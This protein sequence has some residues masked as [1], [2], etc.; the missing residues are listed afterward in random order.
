MA[1]QTGPEDATPRAVALSYGER[2]VAQGSSPRVVASGQGAVAE[3]IIARAHEHGVPVHE[4]RELVAALMHFDLDQHIPPALY[5][6]VAEV[7]TW[8]HRLE[9]KAAP[10]Q[11]E[12]IAGPARERVKERG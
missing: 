8:V 4:S 5:V 11:V 2:E 3:Q 10:A 1:T 9:R 12:S 6:A 7:L